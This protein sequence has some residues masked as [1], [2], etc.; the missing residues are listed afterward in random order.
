MKNKMIFGFHAVTSRLR[1][2]ASSVEEIFVDASRVDGRMKDMIAAAKAA[3]VRVM[4]VDSSRLDKIVGTRRHQGVIAFA[5][6]LSLARNLD[7]LLDAIDGPPLLLILDGITDPHNL[8]ACLR[9]AD[10]MGVHAVI[11]P[12]DK[13]AGL[14][15]TVSKVAC[16]AAETVPYITVTNLARTLRELKEYGIWIVGTDMSGEADLFHCALPESVAWVM[17]NE[18]EGMRRLTREHCDLLVSIPMFGTVESMNVSVSAGMVLSETRRQR[19]LKT[20]Q[21]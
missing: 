5:S 21:A 19:T 10:A 4:P 17:G 18:G 7:E 8:G 3:N 9:T 14:N 12:K 2:E 16:G 11:A 1:H 6:Q 13:S 20:E 15:A